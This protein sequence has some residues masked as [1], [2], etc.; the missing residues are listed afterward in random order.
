M[1]P[2]QEFNVR[3]LY[4]ETTTVFYDVALIRLQKHFNENQGQKNK[5]SE[6]IYSTFLQ[7]LDNVKELHEFFVLIGELI[8]FIDK[9]AYNKTKFLE[10]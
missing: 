2:K 7:S 4:G 9:N 10:S 3:N 8:A 1:N 5:K 6:Q